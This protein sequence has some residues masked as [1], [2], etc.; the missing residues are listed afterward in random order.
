MKKIGVYK[1]FKLY[2][3]VEHDIVKSGGADSR[4]VKG[5]IV[6]FCPDDERPQLGYEEWEAGSKKEAE[7]FIDSYGKDE[8]ENES[9]KSRIEAAKS[10]SQSQQNSRTVLQDIEHRTRENFQITRT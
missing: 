1:R 3:I 2:E 10:L 8:K 9:I 7:D 5:S 6:I 4:Y